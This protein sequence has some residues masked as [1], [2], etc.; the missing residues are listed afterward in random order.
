MRLGGNRTRPRRRTERSK[1]I[2]DGKTV[3]AD[4]APEIELISEGP[5]QS[6]TADERNLIRYIH[7]IWRIYERSH[8]GTIDR[9]PRSR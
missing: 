7:L 9:K 1:V 5:R 6:V 3:H 8:A 4:T 2:S